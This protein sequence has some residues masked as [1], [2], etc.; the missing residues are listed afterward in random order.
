M[1]KLMCSKVTHNPY[2]EEFVT[3][4]PERIFEIDGYQIDGRILEGI[5][6][7]VTFGEDGVVTNVTITD[8]QEK[9]YFEDKFNAPK[10]YP[11][12]KKYAERIIQEGDE[13]E[14]PQHLEDKYFQN[15]I[16]VAFILP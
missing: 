4:I 9:E 2:K 5:K 7:E 8:Q 6:F 1:T 16:N 3:E 10:I 15:G 11:K 12:V 14:I 13:V